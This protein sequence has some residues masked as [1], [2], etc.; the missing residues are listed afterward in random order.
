MSTGRH[1]VTAILYFFVNALTKFRVPIAGELSL[2]SRTCDL[3]M[4][5]RQRQKKKKQLTIAFKHPIRTQVCVFNIDKMR[6]FFQESL[7]NAS[8]IMRFSPSGI[9]LNYTGRFFRIQIQVWWWISSRLHIF[10]KKGMKKK[11]W[12]FEHENIRSKIITHSLNSL[13]SLR[14]QILENQIHLSIHYTHAHI[15]HRSDKN[16]SSNPRPSN[17]SEPRQRFNLSLVSSHHSYL[18]LVQ[19]ISF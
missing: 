1:T 10:E 13:F 15:T 4:S 7:N 5:R 9:L 6:T 19:H 17:D 2:G 11:T 16:V 18:V 12:E 14:I 8:H 3:P